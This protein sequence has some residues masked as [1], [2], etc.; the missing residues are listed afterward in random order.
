LP[1]EVAERALGHGLDAVDCLEVEHALLDV[2][3]E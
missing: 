2:G 1:D 3:H